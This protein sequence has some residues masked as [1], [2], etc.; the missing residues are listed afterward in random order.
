MTRRAR[1]ALCS[2]LLLAV[3]AWAGPLAVRAADGSEWRVNEDDATRLERRTADSKLDPRFGQGGL[4]EYT[5]GHSDAGTAAL[6][7]D[8]AGRPWVAGTSSASGT[9]GPVVMRFAADGK[10]DT[11]WG[12]GGRSSA[13][14]PGQRLVVVDL[15]PRRDGSVWLAGNALTAPAGQHAAVWRLKPDGS[16]DFKFGAGG[17][18]QRAGRDRSNAVSL[19]EAPDGSLAL[20]VELAE[21]NRTRREIYLLPSDGS[22]PQVGE[23]SV[24]DDDDEDDDYL[25]W[26]GQG[27]R[28]ESGDQVAGLSGLAGTPAPEASAAAGSEPSETGQAGF[29]PFGTAS[30]APVFEPPAEERPWGLILGGGGAVLALLALWGWRARAERATRPRG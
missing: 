26:A 11:A 17:L 10:V 3:P 19:A 23:T 15:L 7:V 8:A 21:G 20:G 6:R 22:A 2:L 29:S 13:T 25:E 28:W 9:S 12:V 4:A 16:L 30:A 27:W 5:L 24:S 18:W 14:P 1:A